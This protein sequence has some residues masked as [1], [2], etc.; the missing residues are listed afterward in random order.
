MFQA[1]EKT[2]AKHRVWSGKTW[3]TQTAIET[4]TFIHCRSTFLGGEP[5][6]RWY[7]LID[8]ILKLIGLGPRHVSLPVGKHRTKLK[9]QLP[10]PLLEAFNG[11][12]AERVY[13]ASVLLDVPASRNLGEVER[14]P[15]RATVPDVEPEPVSI[16]Y[17]DSAGRSVIDRIFGPN[18]HV[19]IDLTA[20]VV[21]RG[22]TICGELMVTGPEVPPPIDGVKCQ[23]LHQESVV[24][25]GH[26]DG[27]EFVVAEKRWSLG[28]DSFPFPLRFPVPSDMVPTLD[29]KSFTIEHQFVISLDV[30]GEMS[31]TIPCDVRVI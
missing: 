19:Q 20:A 24:A 5:R 16:R 22:D 23:L 13:E 17:P 10:D 7:N 6:G 12:K 3:T 8:D 26:R 9:I 4:R 31:P 2:W 27:C 25:R 18:V 28:Q 14:L 1:F 15:V 30:P 11:A 21:R 29:G